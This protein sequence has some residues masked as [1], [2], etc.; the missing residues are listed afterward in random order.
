[1]RNLWR[2]SNWA[3]KL[4]LRR[5]L[6]GSMNCGG[7]PPRERDRDRLRDR[8]IVRPWCGIWCAIGWPRCPILPP[9]GLP[10]PA[11]PPP[12]GLPPPA[13][14]PLLLLPPPTFFI[15]VNRSFNDNRV[16]L[17]TWIL[18]ID[19]ILFARNLTLVCGLNACFELDFYFVAAFVSRQMPAR[20]YKKGWLLD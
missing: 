11:P 2:W 14:P 8:W 7:G 6:M 20:T 17:L 5:L 9:I 12:I 13:L 15:I 19:C 16:E 1:M 3:N 10:P 4:R 18:L